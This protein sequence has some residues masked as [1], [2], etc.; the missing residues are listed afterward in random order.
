MKAIVKTHARTDWNAFTAEEKKITENTVLLVGL[1]YNMCKVELVL[2][3]KQEND[4]NRINAKAIKES[5]DNA[6]TV[7]EDK[8]QSV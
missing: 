4:I 8:F 1:L 2:K 6:N 7:L 5:I 3:S